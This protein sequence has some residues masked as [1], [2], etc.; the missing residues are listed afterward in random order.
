MIHPD[1]PPQRRIVWLTPD[2]RSHLWDSVRKALDNEELSEACS[3]LLRAVAEELKIVSQRERI[4]G[5]L[6]SNHV[7]GL[8]LPHDALPVRVTDDE[9][10]A[11]LSIG[12]SDRR[13]KRM[14]QPGPRKQG[15]R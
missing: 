8:M 13:M 2:Q 11:I 14:L 6:V 1:D 5:R 12:I 10:D 3:A 9:A 7:T 4:S 15:R